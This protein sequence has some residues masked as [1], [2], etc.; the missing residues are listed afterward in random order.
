VAWSGNELV[1]V[2]DKGTIIA[3]VRDSLNSTGLTAA[4]PRNLN[5]EIGVAGSEIRV[6][7]PLSLRGSM[8]RL[9]VYSAI[10]VKLIE[11]DAPGAASAPALSIP[12]RHLP[13]GVYIL[14]IRN[15][16]ARAAQRFT[17]TR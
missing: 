1:A 17:L 5:I 16:M 11:I 13:R 15:G 8:T 9:A 2:G 3:L 10:G 4:F 7:L 6:H 12:I 14:E